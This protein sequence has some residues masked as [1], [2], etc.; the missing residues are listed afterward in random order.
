M[1]DELAVLMLGLTALVSTAANLY[2]VSSI[3]EQGKENGYFVFFHFMVAGMTG[4]FLTADLFNLFV[5]FEIVLMSSYAMV[6]YTG[7]K[8]AL[9]TSLKYVVLNL[10]GS[11]LMLIA[12]GGLYSVTGTVNMAHMARILAAG[13]VNMVPVL[14]LSTVLFCVFG[15]KSGI[16]P[17]Q[18]WV[19]TVYSNSPPPAA[20]MM[21][22]ISKKVGIY[23]VIRLYFTVFSQA[24]VPGS[25]L[26]F[27]GQSVSTVTGGLILLLALITVVF[28]GIGAVNRDRLEKLLSYS[29][30][31]QVGFI[32]V[33]IALGLIHGSKIAVIAAIVYMLNHGLAKSSLFMINGVL[34]RITGTTKISELGGISERSI[35]LTAV[36]SVSML[37]LVGFPPLLGFFSKFL[38][39]NTA[40][41]TA[42][43]IS[44][45]FVFLGAV[46]TLLYA[47]KTI[48]SVFFGQKIETDGDILL[49]EKAAITL[50]AAGILALGIGFEQTYVFAELAAE[51]VL[52]PETYIETVLGGTK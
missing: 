23:A 17:F 37:S 7:T 20:A 25:A 46:L 3:S 19:P 47:S 44:L 11:T 45:A 27:Q 28:G 24:A 4:A 31:G 49:L 16:V 36:F 29:S 18:F 39:F 30:I 2:S 1:A 26:V 38:V 15:I 35:W 10:I 14:G 52:Q 8:R 21:A 6:A 34:D 22:G 40:V 5:M 43:W 13:E 33:P 41:S 9:F 42:S 48:M 51:N 12:I 32:Y 50:L